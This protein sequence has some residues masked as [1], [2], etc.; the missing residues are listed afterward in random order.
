MILRPVICLTS[1]TVP[2]SVI[3]VEVSYLLNPAHSVLS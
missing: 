3:S 1:S 2:L